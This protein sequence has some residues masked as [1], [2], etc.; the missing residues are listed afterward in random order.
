M[1]QK[2]EIEGMITALFTPLNEKERIKEGSFKELIDFQIEN[3]INGF[4]SLGTA[5]EGMKLSIEKRKRAAEIIVNHV[6][7][8]IPVIVHVGTPDTEMTVELA[9]HAEKIGA[10]AVAAVAP[11]YYKP[12]L[13]GLIQ[14]YK[15]IGNATSLPL[16]LYNNPGRQGYN[17]APEEFGKVVEEVPQVV[18][19]K[20]TS[21]SIE[22]IQR[23]VQKFGETH[24]IIGAGDTIVFPVFA[25]GARAHISMVSNVFPQLTTRIYKEFKNGNYA[26]ARE[27]QFL[28][29]DVIEVLKH[30]PYLSTYKEATKILYNI[31][32]GTVS[33][34]LRP[35]KKEE[36]EKLREEMENVKDK[37]RGYL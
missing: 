37:L 23:Y 13:E 36:A 32:L 18:G 30:G 11:F 21:Y 1:R 9:E 12:D 2:F 29:N 35:M 26:K 19:I 10:D 7:G 22:Q 6:K 25:V 8:R 34:P 33:S 20:D 28:L 16:F 3:G 24:L 17:I 4:F 27:I 14:H 31:D 5:G 15:R